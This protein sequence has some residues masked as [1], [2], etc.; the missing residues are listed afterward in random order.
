MTVRELVRRACTRGGVTIVP[1]DCYEE[2]D[3]IDASIAADKAEIA[4]LRC[5]SISYATE[6][7]T[8]EKAR[9][10]M[11]ATARQEGRDE[12]LEMAAVVAKSFDKSIMSMT[13]EDVQACEIADAIRA[14]KTPTPGASNDRR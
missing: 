11:L 12:G 3:A 14:L 10:D 6:I 7:E 8:V 1:G 13:R 4:R 5:L 9:D 2:A